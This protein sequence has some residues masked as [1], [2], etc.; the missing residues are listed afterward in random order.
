MGDV[1][2]SIAAI[3]SLYP[4]Q[5]S[6]QRFDVTI[7]QSICETM[8]ERPIIAQAVGTEQ[9]AASESQKRNSATTGMFSDL[10][11]DV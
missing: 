9:E 8:A 3:F 7:E 5:P 2:T 6:H 1:G 10:T 11:V 4:Y